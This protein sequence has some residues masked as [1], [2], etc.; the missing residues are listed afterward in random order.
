MRADIE[1][2]IGPR[3]TLVRAFVVREPWGLL[4]YCTSLWYIS[5][6]R[7]PQLVCHHDNCRELSRLIP[8]VDAVTCSECTDGWEM[9][10]RCYR[11]HREKK[12]A[13]V[14]HA[15]P[16]YTVKELDEMFNKRG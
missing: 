10:P 6:M 7:P 2:L 3:P 16:L 4:E 14:G 1:L 8:H 15:V 11:E 9:H 13:G 12:H 5:P